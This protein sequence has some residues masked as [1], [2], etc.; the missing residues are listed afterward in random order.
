MQ[1]MQA[2]NYTIR[3]PT[4]RLLQEVNVLLVG[5]SF[6]NNEGKSPFPLVDQQEE[7]E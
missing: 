3:I 6:G 4:T 5:C 2:V 1:L 7:L